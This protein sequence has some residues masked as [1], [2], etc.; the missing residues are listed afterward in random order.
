MQLTHPP[1][2]IAVLMP[3]ESLPSHMAHPA[4]K[5]AEKEGEEEEE[6]EKEEEKEKEKEKE[7]EEEETPVLIMKPELEE[8][9]KS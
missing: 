9:P 5:E 2:S 6:E 7:E 4:C 8:T 3:G 1:E